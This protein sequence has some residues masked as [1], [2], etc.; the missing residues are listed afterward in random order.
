MAYSMYITKKREIWFFFFVL[1]HE[2]NF[3][4][5]HLFVILGLKTKTNDRV[6]IDSMVFVFMCEV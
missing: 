2:N 1:G 6:V 4:G 3:H 5:V